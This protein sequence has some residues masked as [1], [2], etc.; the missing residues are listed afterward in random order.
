[1]G[2]EPVLLWLYLNQ[3]LRHS[4]D[5]AHLEGY[6]DALFEFE[7]K[8]KKVCDVSTS[9]LYKL[10][11]DVQLCTEMNLFHS[12]QFQVSQGPLQKF[13]SRPAPSILSHIQ[14]YHREFL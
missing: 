8:L 14:H 4:T 3:F 7:S 2:Q 13:L 11:F 9:V 1:M 6:H 12:A 10:P 5:I